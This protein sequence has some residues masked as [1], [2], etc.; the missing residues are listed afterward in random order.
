MYDESI[1]NIHCKCGNE[2][3]SRQHGLTCPHRGLVRR[4]R[5]AVKSADTQQGD[6]RTTPEAHS[7]AGAKRRQ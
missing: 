5:G 6:A 7:D 1:K 2:Y 4:P 3:S